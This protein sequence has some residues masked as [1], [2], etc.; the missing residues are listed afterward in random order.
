MPFEEVTALMEAE[1]KDWHIE[2][3][4]Y[5]LFIRTSSSLFSMVELLRE[6]LGKFT[7][8]YLF[9][10]VEPKVAMGRGGRT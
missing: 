3:A 8:G 1:T 7:G 10:R 2:E 4:G 5:C 9:S 6:L